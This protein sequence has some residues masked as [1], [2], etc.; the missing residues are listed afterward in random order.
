VTRGLVRWRRRRGERGAVAVEAALITPVLCLLVFGMI[1]FAFVMRDYSVVSSDVRVGARI[2]S[3]GAGSGPGTCDTYT[4]APPCTP[5]SSPALAQLAADAIQREGSAM[6]PSSINYIL[7]YKAN[8]KGYPCTASNCSDSNTTMPTTCSG[9]SSCV[10][11]TWQPAAN[12][13]AGAFR[14]ADGS[15]NS[16]TISAC[17]PGNATNPLDRVGVYMNATHK[18]MTGLFGAQV[19]LSDKAVFDFEPLPTATCNGTGAV[20]TGGHS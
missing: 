6:P 7:V 20:A 14:Y 15:W 19:T 17:F 10:R 8:S 1:E 9:Y 4:G 5:A 2:A 16:S 3:T 13:G 18:M 12:A 11:F